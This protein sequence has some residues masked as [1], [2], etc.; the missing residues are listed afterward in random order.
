MSPA[1]TQSDRNT[2]QQ[3]L[4]LAGAGGPAARTDLETAEYDW[5][6]PCRFVPAE[7][8][9]LGRFV[10]EVGERISQGLGALLRMP[11]KLDPAPMKQS[12]A[13]DLRSGF[14]ETAGYSVPLALESG[15]A[16][17]LVCLPA[18]TAL[19]WVRRLLGASAAGADQGKQLSEVERGLL[20]DI[21]AVVADALSAASRPA[22]GPGFKHVER[23]F[24]AQP[25]L[26]GEDVSEYCQMSFRPE[27]P[28]DA[29]PLCVLV[30][31]EVLAAVCAGQA[32]KRAERP[33]EDVRRDLLGHLENVAVVATVRLGSSQVPLRD[34]L[35]LEPGD[36]LVTTR[37][38]DEP[39]ELLVQRKVVLS[40]FPARS[41]GKYA[42]KITA[43]GPTLARGRAGRPG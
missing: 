12:Y 28:A 5:R 8:K 15:Q 14:S 29:P 24:Q 36:V 34:L 31:S 39:V 26:P 30:L 22:G 1:S 4:R 10:Q 33:A 21:A 16:C 3:L 37:R 18:A 7:L 6:V 11:L 42:L 13:G 41:A 25:D 32:G 9:K 38:V 19:S 17:G 20:W 40:G 23:L 43:P 2:I 27:T 35:S